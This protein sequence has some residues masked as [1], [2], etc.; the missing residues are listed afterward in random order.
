MAEYDPKPGSIVHV[1]IPS[2]DVAATK[3]FY[4]EVF[5]WTFQDVP[6]M[7]YTLFAAPTPPNGGIFVPSEG[8]SGVLN[9]I[10]VESVEEISEKIAA[11]G[12]KVLVPRREVPGQGWFAVFQDPQGAVLA[13]WENPP[14]A[15]E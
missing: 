7:N 1:E 14:Q 10:L 5:G 8:P 2:K 3:R 9:Y 15:Q 6:E 13:V 11:E 4:G 12:G